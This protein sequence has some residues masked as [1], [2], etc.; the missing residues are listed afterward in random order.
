[1]RRSCATRWPRPLHLLAEKPLVTRIEDGIDLRR[2]ATPAR[3]VTW[4]AQE[5]RY[6]PPVAE[7][8]PHGA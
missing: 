6:M 7:T 8:D 5:Y 1:M 3:A 2:S 4:V